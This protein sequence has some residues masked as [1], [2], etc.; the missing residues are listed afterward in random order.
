MRDTSEHL[1]GFPRS[2]LSVGTSNLLADDLLF[3][4]GR[5]VF[6]SIEGL[7]LFIEIECGFKMKAV[8]V[9]RDTI[10]VDRRH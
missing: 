10:S 8:A 3:F 7:I 2:K 6:L 5:I 1:A 4:S 9:H